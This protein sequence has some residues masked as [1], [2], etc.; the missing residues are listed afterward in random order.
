[1]DAGLLDAAWQWAREN[2]LADAALFAVVGVGIGLLALGARQWGAARLAARQLESVE[3][4]Q[5]QSDDAP[6]ETEEDA[7]THTPLSILWT[8]GIVFA[9]SASFPLAS[10]LA[11]ATGIASGYWI[12]TGVSALMLIFAYKFWNPSMD[13]SGTRFADVGAEAD[14]NHFSIGL[15]VGSVVILGL[16]ATIAMGSA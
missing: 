7:T 1:M 6:D 13:D 12:A 2:E 9:A 3:A 10:L 14:D 5:K 8:G 11:Q 4:W 16:V 15:I